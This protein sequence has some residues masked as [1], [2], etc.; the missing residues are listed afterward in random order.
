MLH[1]SVKTG[2]LLGVESVPVDVEV[3]VAAGLPAFTVVGLPDA[4]V[5]ESRERVRSALRHCG[6][7]MPNARIVVNLAPGPLKKHGTG[8]DL[9]IAIALLV[10]TGQ[11]AASWADGVFAVGELSLDGTI[12]PTAGTLAHAATAGQLGYTLLCPEPN[13]SPSSMVQTRSIAHL[14]R[15]RGRIEEL[16]TTPPR[17]SLPRLEHN[18]FGDVKGHAVAQRALV[19]AAAGGHNV[20]LIGPPGSGKTMLARC[21]P[22]ILPPLT[23]AERE[24][25]ARIHSVAG[26][27]ERRVLAGERPFRAPHHCAT[28]AGLVG[29]GSPPRPGEASLAHNGVLFLDE[30]PEFAPSALQTLR[31][32]MEEGE[33]VLVRAHGRIRIPAR[34]SL[35]AAANPCPCGYLG[36]P[37]KECTCAPHR[38]ESYRA[39]VGGPLLD[40]IDIVCHIARPD[41]SVLVGG[42]DG[43][44]SADMLQSVLRAREYASADGRPPSSGLTGT[45]LLAA[46]RL[47]DD[48]G[49]LET[50]ARDAHLSGR[51]ITRLLRVARTLADLD[52]SVRVNG[53]HLAEA[54]MY[55]GEESR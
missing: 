49:M 39:R 51:G 41:P 23:V 48:A 13:H 22:S 30:L 11:T 26:V 34:F 33:I 12:R 17:T 55:R 42:S 27:D 29:G 37:V 1:A 31:Q 45:D 52:C 6:F 9:P 15:L 24:E 43:S 2:T 40:R 19:V 54:L 53:A 44:S 5:Q 50:M 8:F 10:A 4:A 35:V 21:L 32:P 20:L 18:D 38:I 46:C 25:T 16:E 7:E 3:E 28:V 36:D 47:G 14:N